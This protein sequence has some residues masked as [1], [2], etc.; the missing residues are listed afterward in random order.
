MQVTRLDMQVT[1]LDICNI[2]SGVGLERES[3]PELEG[4]FFTPVSSPVPWLG[5]C[6]GV[7]RHQ[8]SFPSRSEVVFLFKLMTPH[9]LS[10]GPSF[11]KGRKVCLFF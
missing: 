6:A 5:L 2:I 10:P 9:G 8:L 4:V 1:R 7:C 3:G 11:L